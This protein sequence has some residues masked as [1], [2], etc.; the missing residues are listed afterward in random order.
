[1]GSTIVKSLRYAALSGTFLAVSWALASPMTAVAQQAAPSPPTADAP[2]P[3]PAPAEPSPGYLFDV[4]SVGTAWGET[5]KKY[6]IFLNGGVFTNVFGYL[7]GRKQGVQG[8]GE[9][10][11]GLDL[12]LKQMF[13]I[14]GA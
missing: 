11:L 5:L 14:E 2:A 1:M 3:P 6:G 8:Q 13:G 9:V 12:D 10:T 7:G 4:S